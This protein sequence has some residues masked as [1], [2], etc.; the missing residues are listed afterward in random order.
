MLA[1]LLATT[2]WAG[3]AFGVWKLIPARSTPDPNQKALTLRIEP[4]L[5]GEVFTVETQAWDGRSSTLSTILYLDGKPREYQDSACSGTQ[6][7]RRLDGGAVEILRACEGG[8]HVR[9]VR[10]SPSPAVLILD[11][12][13]LDS[14]GRRTVRRLVLEKH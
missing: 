11:I 7:S 3:S 1:T 12:E 14:N 4:H 10:R 6:S 5:R 2:F 8:G 13:E 9:L